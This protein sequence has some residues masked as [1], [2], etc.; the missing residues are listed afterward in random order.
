[1]A[2]LSLPD[3]NLDWIRC[4]LIEKVA[5]ANIG[6]ENEEKEEEQKTLAPYKYKV[7]L[8]EAEFAANNL[9]FFKIKNSIILLTI[10]QD[11][12]NQCDCIDMGRKENEATTTTNR[13]KN[14]WEYQ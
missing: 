9:S 11:C 8:A 6:R 3:S 2:S 10:M 1:M 4:C 7:S 14:E 12:L 5:V 13:W